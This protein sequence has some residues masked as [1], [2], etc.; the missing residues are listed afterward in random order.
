MTPTIK[1]VKY[2][3]KSH[4]PGQLVTIDSVHP[5][6]PGGVAT[7][8]GGTRIGTEKK[9]ARIPLRIARVM[10]LLAIFPVCDLPPHAFSTGNAFRQSRQLP[11]FSE[12][13][14]SSCTNARL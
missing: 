11:E 12:K 4:V 5:K 9:S 13:L 3:T 8:K 7:H 14:T 1:K 6:E 10:N 2:A